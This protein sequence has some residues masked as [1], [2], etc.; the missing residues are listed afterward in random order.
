[1]YFCYRGLLFRKRGVINLG[2]SCGEDHPCQKDR[3][4]TMFLVKGK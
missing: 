2:M 3:C 4:P 1:M